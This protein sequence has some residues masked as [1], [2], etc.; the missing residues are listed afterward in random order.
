[1]KENAGKTWRCSICGYIHYG[2]E[3]PDTCPICDAKAEDFKEIE[4]AVRPERR[5]AGHDRFIIIGAGISGVSAAEAIRENAPSAEV[6]LISKEE[7][8]PYRYA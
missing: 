1:M 4:V 7:E 8:I 3:A 5:N 2:D 6:I